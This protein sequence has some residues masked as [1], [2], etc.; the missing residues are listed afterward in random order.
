MRFRWVNVRFRRRYLVIL[1]FLMVLP[2]IFIVMSNS[3][4][5]P[6]SQRV[7]PAA[8]PPSPHCR[9]GDPLA[10]VYNPLRFRVLSSCQLASGTVKSVTLQHDGDQR[11]DVLPDAQ[12]TKLLAVGNLNYN[13]GML[14]LEL[15]PHDQANITIPSVGQHITF[16][17]PL[18]Y[19]AENQWNA[20]YPVWSIRAD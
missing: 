8:S 6:S 7:Q 17:G 11:I 2:T 3:L 20:I 16:V 13:G 9:T 19:D 18:V 12:Y 1:V 15:I 5:H 10:G 14:V 4:S